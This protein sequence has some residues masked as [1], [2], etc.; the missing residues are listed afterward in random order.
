MAIRVGPR[1]EVGRRG[2]ARAEE[3]PGGDCR[4]ERA[5]RRR[6]SEEC[7]G[8]WLR[9]REGGK[10]SREEILVVFDGFDL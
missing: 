8:T 6:S 9:K 2:G 10:S 7:E 4:E 1:L 3:R 5:R